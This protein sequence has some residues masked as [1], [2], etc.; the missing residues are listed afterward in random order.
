MR[1]RPD[2]APEA[3]NKLGGQQRIIMQPAIH[4]PDAHEEAARRAEEFARLSPEQRWREI[5][6]LFACGW[7]MVRASPN[8]QAIEKRFADQEE[9]WQR[10]QKELFARH[11]G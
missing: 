11:G 9:E 5:A 3:Y 6:E 8:R 10:I 4:F 2:C 1:R 7:A